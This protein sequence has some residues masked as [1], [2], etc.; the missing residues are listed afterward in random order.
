MKF[1]K[2]VHGFG[3]MNYFY[4]LWNVLSFVIFVP[5]SPRQRNDRHARMSAIAQH[6]LEG[7][8]AENSAKTRFHPIV[9]LSPPRAKNLPDKHVGSYWNTPDS[10]LKLDS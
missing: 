10:D 3:L 7:F 8:L 2:I 5:K 6:P 4:L 1:I 9:L